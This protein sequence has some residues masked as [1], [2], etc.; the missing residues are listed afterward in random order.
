MLSYIGMT[1]KND[2]L[3]NVLTQMSNDVHDMKTDNTMLAAK[4]ANY[5]YKKGSAKTME[6]AVSREES[7][8]D[9]VLA[10]LQ[11]RIS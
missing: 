10:E 1:T 8:T 5:L 7:I 9:S 4:I 2:S 3:F 6:V 11:K